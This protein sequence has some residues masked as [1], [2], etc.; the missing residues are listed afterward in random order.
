M[1]E[2]DGRE[3]LEGRLTLMGVMRGEPRITLGSLLD[4][5]SALT[6]RWGEG[7]DLVKEAHELHVGQE[8]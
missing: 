6:S 3:V 5:L 8:V 7:R 1:E 2:T 4:Q